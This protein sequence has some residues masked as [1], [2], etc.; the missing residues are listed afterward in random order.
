MNRPFTAAL[1]NLRE[2]IGNDAEDIWSELDAMLND[3]EGTPRADA[4][5]SA[6]GG[7]DA[8]D[9]IGVL[10]IVTEDLI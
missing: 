3:P 2:L 5:M 4:I 8:K 9:M 1:N 6:L 10:E 7:V